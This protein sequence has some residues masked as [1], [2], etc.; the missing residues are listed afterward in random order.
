VLYFKRQ[1]IW[2]LPNGF[3]ILYSLKRETI[4]QLPNGLERIQNSQ[5]QSIGQLPNGL[6]DASYIKHSIQ[7]AP[8]T[9]VVCINV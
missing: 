2:L 7:E 4:G 1:S 6:L 5:S 9:N 3:Q 8:L